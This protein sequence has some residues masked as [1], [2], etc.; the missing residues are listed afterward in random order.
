VTPT[1]VNDVAIA[2]DGSAYFTD[3]QSPRLYKLTPAS[4]GGYTFEVFTTFPSGPLQ[5][6]PGFNLNGI[7]VTPNGR[8]LIVVQSNTGKLFRIDTATKAVIEIDLGGETVTAGEGIFL[9]GRTLYVV[10]NSAELIVKIRLNGDLSSGTVVSATTSPLFQFPTTVARARGRL[11]V[12]NSQFDKRAPGQSP[13]LPFSIV[14]V[15]AP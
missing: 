14:R 10:R 15:R 8:Y 12:V 1:F 5:Y 4:D 7:D 11:L 13:E 9:Q 2:R 3:S 6:Q